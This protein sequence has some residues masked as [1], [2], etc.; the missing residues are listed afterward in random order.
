MT[1]PW[2]NKPL[3]SADLNGKT[4]MVVGANTGIGIEAAKHLAK[5]NP[6]RVIITCRT[7]EKGAIATKGNS[8]TLFPSI[9]S[10]THVIP[11]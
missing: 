8:P 1:S 2:P 4:V 11:S 6:D 7:D 10:L 5:M 3:Y 9:L